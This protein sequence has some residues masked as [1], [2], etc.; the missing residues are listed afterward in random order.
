VTTQFRP[1]PEAKVAVVTGGASG[2]GASVV[3]M[4]RESGATVLCVDIAAEPTECRVDITDD[5]SVKN[6]AATIRRIHGH[7]NILV[8]C[9]GTIA[10][11]TATECSSEDWDRVFAV[12]V[13]AAWSMSKHLIPLMPHGSTIVNV[14]SGAGLRAI[15]DMVAYVAAKH[16]LVGLTRAMA[17]DHAR[18]GVRVNCVCPGLVDTP[19]ARQA[20]K[21]RPA[22]SSQS[23]AAYDSYLI[24]RSA[25]SAEI[26]QSICFLASDASSYTT[27]ACLAV[28]G[29]RS[30]H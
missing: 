27:G 19:L 20:Q 18:D 7:C 3:D 11:G 29:G 24:K 4:L 25:T 6:L 17:I 22:R 9:A 15:P 8:N 10:V 16:A 2:I 1:G 14:A 30:M 5:R 21:E 23:I 13:R 12:N 26:A 28:D